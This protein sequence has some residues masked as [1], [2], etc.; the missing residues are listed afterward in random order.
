MLL[1]MRESVRHNFPPRFIDCITGVQILFD[2]NI[3]KSRD[4]VFMR[5]GKRTR[6]GRNHS[7]RNRIAELSELPRDVVLGVPLLTLTGQIELS[8]ENY[9][10][11]IE[12][13]ELLVRIRTKAGQIRIAGDHLTVDYYTGDE[14]KVL[15]HI[16]SI[17]YLDREG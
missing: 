1:P 9:S 5:T 6:R 11:I 14:M 10:G 16:T 15:G 17:E 12:Y 4:G 7:L 3:I 2:P 13:T 8:I